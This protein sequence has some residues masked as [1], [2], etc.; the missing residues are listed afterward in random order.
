M[1]VAALIFFV[2]LSI[3]VSFISIPNSAIK[4]FDN[5]YYL[6]KNT[7]QVKNTLDCKNIKNPYAISFFIC[8]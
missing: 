8:K 1:K 3:I 7:I 4:I 2:I 6:K 5:Y